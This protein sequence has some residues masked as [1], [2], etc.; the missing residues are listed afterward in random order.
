MS[1]PART[2]RQSL[3]NKEE[4]TMS[5]RSEMELEWNDLVE[6]PAARVPVCLCLDTS[7]SMSGDPVEELNGGVRLFFE[8]VRRDEVARFSA[9]V[10]VVVFGNGG[11]RKML[12]FAV[13]DRQ[14]LP[15]LGAGGSTPMG[16]AVNMGLD[17]LESR[18]RAYSEAGTDYYQPWLVLMTDGQPN[19]DHEELKRSIQRVND[20]VSRRKLT[21]FPVGIGAE[22]DMD[23][24]GLYSPGRTPLKLQGL[25]FKDFFAWLSKSVARV[26]QS[27]PGER[28]PLDVEEIKGW[29]EL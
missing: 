23:V 27:V 8:E 28:V 26:S 11:Y 21:V 14:A 9:E 12:D 2:S 19:G 25:K 17:L 4:K 22:A 16:E 15:V 20:L 29:A 3:F 5:Q 10:C 7:G 18:K 6:N 24:L 13:V 1:A